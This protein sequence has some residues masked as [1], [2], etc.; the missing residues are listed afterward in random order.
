MYKKFTLI[1]ITGV[2]FFGPIGQ[3]LLFKYTP[4]YNLNLLTKLYDDASWVIGKP[5][6]VIMGSSHARYHI[7]PAEIAKLNKDYELKD[8]VNIGENAA[9]PFEMYT[10]FMKNR[11]KF[12]KVQIVYYTLEP[13]MLSEKYY[14][15]NKYESILLNYKQWKYL[16]NN[17]NKKNNYFFPFQTFVQTLKFKTTNRSKSNG[18]SA[19]KHKKFNKYSPGRVSKSIYEPLEL[20]PVSL[21]GINSFKKLKEELD[22]QGAELIFVLTPT[23]TWQKYYAKEAKVYDDM[24]IKLL[25]TAIGDS[26]VI[27]SFWPEDFALQYEDF[28]DDTHIAHS[29]ALKF[30]QEVFYDIKK[31]NNLKLTAIKNTFSYRFISF[32]KQSEKKLI[33]NLNIKSLVWK[34]DKSGKI[35]FENGYLELNT[36]DIENFVYLDTK[37]KNIKNIESVFISMEL[38]DEKLKMISISLRNGKEYGHFFVRAD[39]FKDG[40][41]KLSKIN[42]SQS[43]KD[44]EFNNFD[45]FTIRLYPKNK[46][47]IHNFRMNEIKFYK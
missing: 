22:K 37:F 7:I 19:L 47:G 24:L 13:H 39:E 8:I 46:G 33:G 44:F 34:T 45:G 10:S 42:I 15:Y 12:S 11:D 40:K 16:E 28:K 3:F 32:H 5:K 30:T 41:I 14:P 29:G 25:N 35:T 21:H 36:Y 23:Y 4:I 31:Y 9:S 1:I 38:P 26:K 2:I 20:F 17:H 18:Y 27:G 43:S 6:I